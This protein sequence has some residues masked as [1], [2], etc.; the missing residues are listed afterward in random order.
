[1]TVD[2]CSVGTDLLNKNTDDNTA[3]PADTFAGVG[4]SCNYKPEEI[5]VEM[6]LEKQLTITTAESCTGGLIGATLVNV[7]GV[8][9]VFKEGYITYANESKQKLLGVS[10]DTL[11]KYGAVSE[12]TA[13]EMAEGALKATNADVSIAVT[14]IAGPDG[15]TDEKPVG[16]VY[17]A[18]AHKGKTVVRRHVFEGDRLQVRTSTVLYALDLVCRTIS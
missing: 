15:G 12:Q 2:N 8:S 16:L 9:S 17:M 11:A 10:E 3:Y 5:V 7:P 18:C 1:M 13:R 6:L 14:G 4:L